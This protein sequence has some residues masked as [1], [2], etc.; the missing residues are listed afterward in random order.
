MA[1]VIVLGQVLLVEF[2]GDMFRVTSLSLRE[3]L[4]IIVC[5]SPVLWIGE[6]W[7]GVMRARAK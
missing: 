1:G 7:R 3:W 4:L 5:T 6:I 2:G